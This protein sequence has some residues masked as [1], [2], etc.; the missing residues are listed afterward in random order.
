MRFANAIYL[1]NSLGL[2]KD[3]YYNPS[4]T[5][6]KADNKYIHMYIYIL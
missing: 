3:F 1:C 4:F 2:L 6:G 5:I